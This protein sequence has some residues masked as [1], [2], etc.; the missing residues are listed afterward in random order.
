MVREYEWSPDT[1]KLILAALSYYLFN[2]MWIILKNFPF[3]VKY[4]ITQFCLFRPD[5]GVVLLTD[6]LLKFDQDQDGEQKQ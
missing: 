2:K 6:L 4:S 1:H 5:I 3:C